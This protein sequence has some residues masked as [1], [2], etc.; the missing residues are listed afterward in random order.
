MRHPGRRLR[1]RRVA[2]AARRRAA[3]WSPRATSAALA[4]AVPAVRAV[5]GRG[6]PARRPTRG[7]TTGWST[8]TSSLYH[9]SAVRDRLLRPP[10]RARA[11][12][13]R[14]VHRVPHLAEPVTILSSRPRPAG[15]AVMDRPARDDDSTLR[16]DPTAAGC[17]TGR[18][19]TTWACVAR[20]AQ[21]AGWIAG[22]APAVMV[23]DVSV[24]VTAL[25][26]LMGVPVVAVAMPGDRS[27]PAHRLGYDLA[28]ALL[29]CWPAEVMAPSWP[30]GA[31][32]RT[33]YRRRVLPV[34]PAGSRPP[35][36]VDGPRRRV[37]VLL[38]TRWFR[39]R[40]RRY[41]PAV[42]AR[43]RTGTGTSSARRR[44]RTDPGRPCAR[45]TWWSPT[46][47]RTPSPRWL[48]PGRLPS[49]SRN[50]RPH[51]EQFATAGAA[52][53]RRPAIVRALACPVGLAGRAGEAAAWTDGAGHDGARGRR[54]TRRR[55]IEPWP[56][57]DCRGAVT[58]GRP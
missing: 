54:R 33:W 2:R 49:S 44:W 46:P 1:P 52:R 53:A 38:G 22:H 5:A 32:S 6:S 3:G 56:R 11:P 23:V 21:I 42:A 47:D 8:S 50:G 37:V 35:H 31:T 16:G 34:R 55:V 10:P 13:A 18:H 43:F 14:A 48:R 17:C 9:E 40:R 57:R 27:D 4:A 7:R 20:M 24:E 58:C 29:A 15:G 39:P 51:D 41:W 26:R 45:P 25:C 28:D 12:P 36:V 19:R 30:D